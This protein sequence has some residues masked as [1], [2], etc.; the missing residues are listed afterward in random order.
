[1][2]HDPQR[3][4]LYAYSRNNPLL[5]VDPTGEAIA[6]WGTDEQRA[7]QLAAWK[8]VVGGG[9]AGEYL[10]DNTYTDAEGN[11]GHYLGIYTNGP[12]GKGLAFENI[13][14]VT[15]AL[16]NVVNAPQIGQLDLVPAGS[17]ATDGAYVQYTIGPAQEGKNQVP[18]VTLRNQKDNRWHFSVLD[19]APYGTLPA[20]L[21]SDGKPGLIN[22]NILVGHEGLGHGFLPDGAASDRKAVQL[23]NKVR[24]LKDPRAPQRTKHELAG[25]N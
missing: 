21:M 14:D 8:A 22:Q 18:A 16:S 5:Y 7:Q 6:L 25:T 9:E 23:E 12:D 20:G 4:N 1:M 24:T 10:Y 3:F 17:T 13:S 19:Q 2:Q 11:T 15:G